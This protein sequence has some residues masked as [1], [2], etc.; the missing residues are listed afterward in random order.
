[1]LPIN[2]TLILVP[3]FLPQNRFSAHLTFWS[4][5][6]DRHLRASVCLVPGT[7]HFRVFYSNLTSGAHKRTI[8]RKAAAAETEGEGER[9]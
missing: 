7:F 9:E 8:A 1:M 3:G 2:D 4:T 5:D 6:V